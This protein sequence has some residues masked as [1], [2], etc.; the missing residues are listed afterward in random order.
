MWVCLCE[1]PCICVSLHLSTHRRQRQWVPRVCPCQCP[2]A[3]EAELWAVTWYGDQ[4]QAPVRAVSTLWCWASFQLWASACAYVGCAWW[5]WL[6][7]INALKPW[8][9]AP[10]STV[11]DMGG[12]KCERLSLPS[13]SPKLLHPCRGEHI[14]WNEVWKW[15]QQFVTKCVFCLKNHVSLSFI[16]MFLSFFFF[17]LLGW[18]TK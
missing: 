17:N 16:I 6:W 9:M 14:A 1:W 10:E 8:S 3:A 4:S 7:R 18:H 13:A 12:G 2:P 15:F 5:W 11:L